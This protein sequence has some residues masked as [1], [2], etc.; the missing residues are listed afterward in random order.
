MKKKCKKCLVVKQVSLFYRHAQMADGHLNF[1]IDCVKARV[2]QHRIQ[3]VD[4]IRAY[5]RNRPNA[6]QRSK[7]K[8]ERHQY[9]L[10]HEDGY[11]EKTNEQVGLD[12]KRYPI[13]RAARTI[14]GNAIRKGLLTKEPCVKC[15]ATVNIHAHHEDY[16]K[17][18]KVI[19]FCHEHHSER[20]KAINE[21][22]RKGKDL[23]HRG[24]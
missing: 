3:N 19:W 9:R 16:Y 11:R 21:Q 22:I 6:S 17:P 24:F 20:H 4:K 13:K 5:D 23:S 1:C 15:G 8:Q 18:L 10:K 12:R 7:A 14:T 2:E